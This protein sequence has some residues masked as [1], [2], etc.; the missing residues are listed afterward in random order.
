MV[1]SRSVTNAYK[2]LAERLRGLNCQEFRDAKG[3]HVV[4]YNP[5]T[6]QKIGV[7]VWGNKD[8]KL[9]TIRGI[10]RSLGISRK[11]FGPIK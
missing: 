2:E 5:A 11:E 7:P 10:I 9:G 1:P 4:W 3:S 8:L 6:D